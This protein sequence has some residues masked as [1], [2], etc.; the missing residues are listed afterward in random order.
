MPWYNDVM[1]ISVIVPVFNAE[2]YLERCLNSVI[3]ALGDFKGEILLVDNGSEDN[4]L[5]PRFFIVVLKISTLSLDLYEFH[6]SPYALYRLTDFLPIR[7]PK[8]MNGIVPKK[9][10]KKP[11]GVRAD[12][13]IEIKNITANIGQQAIETALSVLPRVFVYTLSSRSWISY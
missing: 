8:I 10:S 5:N 12:T 9:K 6:S 7:F 1:I 13:I 11:Y 2:K 3:L 4:S